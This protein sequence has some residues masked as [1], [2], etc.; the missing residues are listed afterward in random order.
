MNEEELAAWKLKKAEGGADVDS[1]G[2]E[3]TEDQI[4][5][6]AEE[7]DRK[8]YGRTWIWEGY[9]NEGRKQQWLDTAEML[10]HVNPHVL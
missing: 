9:F 4:A 7:A 6:K 1:D 10:K 3:L 2:V 8:K 5:A